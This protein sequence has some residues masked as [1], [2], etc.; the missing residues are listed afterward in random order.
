[1]EIA[2]G[3]QEDS[4]GLRP[5]Y[6]VNNPHG[7]ERRE[8]IFLQTRRRITDLEEQME[9]DSGVR[10]DWSVSETLPRAGYNNIKPKITGNKICPVGAA[11]NREY[12]P[13]TFP[14]LLSV[15][16][17]GGG[18][19]NIKAKGEGKINIFLPSDINNCDKKVT[20]WDNLSYAGKFIDTIGTGVL[21]AG[22]VDTEEA[23][24]VHLA[25]AEEVPEEKNVEETS[26]ADK[27]TEI[28][29]DRA[30][31][32]V[33]KRQKVTA[34]VMK[35]ET[36]GNIME[37]IETVVDLNNTEE[38]LAV[39]AETDTVELVDKKLVVADSN[40]KVNSH[41]NKPNCSQSGG[42]TNTRQINARKW[43][44]GKSGLYGW[45]KVRVKKTLNM[46]VEILQQ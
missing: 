20:V 15:T 8:R 3:S 32:I 11:H 45:R 26:Y 10:D 41:L 9:T 24:E 14:E 34:Q 18:T 21:D 36:G 37:E 2:P 46:K 30:T 43:V 23:M 28:L 38:M 27:E 1:M 42:L 16:V 13:H 7:G 6:Y 4:Q 29:P 12:K 31:K 33:S 5:I 17:S 35:L 40:S 39:D 22:Y 19:A 25:E 44:R